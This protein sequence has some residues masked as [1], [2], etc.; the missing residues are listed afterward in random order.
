[1]NARTPPVTLSVCVVYKDIHAWR[2]AWRLLE[3][4]RESST[5][6][7]EVSWFSFEEVP[8]FQDRASRLGTVASLTI[9]ATSQQVTVP[10]PV[11]CWLLAIRNQDPEHQGAL[12]GLIS[13]ASPTLAKCPWERLLEITA[14][15]SGRDLFIRSSEQPGCQTQDIFAR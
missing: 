4:L 13:D 9:L 15:E 7:F 8:L 3:G 10:E 6:E 5:A 12:I 14:R 2:D 11:H 1:M